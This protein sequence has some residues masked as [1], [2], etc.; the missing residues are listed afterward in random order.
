MAGKRDYYEVL[1]VSRG[2]TAE[3]V[4]KAFKK[5]ALKYH[6]DRNVGDPEAEAKFKEVT[7]AYDV[8]RDEAKRQ[9]YDRYG[10]AGLDGFEPGGF[11]GAGPGTIN[12]LFEDLIGSFFGGGGG[13]GSRRG[14]RRGRDLQM[15]LDLTLVEAYTGVKKKVVVPRAERCPTCVGS[16]ARPGSRPATC[17][18]CGGQGTVIQRQGFF[19]LQQTCPACAGRGV[20]ITDP[21]PEC[22]GHG[23]VEV[24]RELEIDVPPGVDNGTRLQVRG[25]GEAGEA[26]A[27]RG[28][29]ELVVRVAEH[30]DF[31]REGDDL[32]C[33]VPITFSQAALGGEIEIP[34]LTEKR[35]ITLPRGTQSHRVLR[36]PGLGMPSLRGGRRGDLM[37][38]VVVETPTHLTERQ[39]E[40]LR[41]LAEIEQRNVPPRRKSFL[42]RLRALFGSEG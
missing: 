34:T 14:P 4:H 38:Q 18:R 33:Q 24:R 32:L 5:L 29:L 31:R 27:P 15:A 23:T 2:A 13:R 28:D 12:D 3:E 25:E 26:G 6:P 9:R 20:I 7:E 21:C 11:G 37:V 10:H 19:Q 41:E 16:G 1:G 36:V 17:R 39:E 22:R 8:L 42:E 30:P 40:L 35:T